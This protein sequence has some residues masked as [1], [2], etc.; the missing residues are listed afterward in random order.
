MENH[1]DR[2]CSGRSLNQEPNL[3]GRGRH[4]YVRTK[5]SC[6][7]QN[8]SCFKESEE[9]TF[10]L[11][12]KREIITPIVELIG[13]YS[14]SVTQHLA[15]YYQ[16]KIGLYPRAI[17]VLGLSSNHVLCTNVANSVPTSSIISQF[18]VLYALEGEGVPH[19]ATPAH[20]SGFYEEPI[21]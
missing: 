20:N 19:L 12:N 9:K 16:V 13:M 2:L 15:G 8:I 14:V 17:H 1:G 4:I 5:K 3:W 11:V 18:I 10:L 21:F 7:R 6:F